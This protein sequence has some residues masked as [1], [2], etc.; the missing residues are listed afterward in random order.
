MKN[1]NLIDFFSGRP[2]SK[3]T[4]QDTD[5]ND[6]LVNKEGVYLGCLKKEDGKTMRNLIAE[7]SFK[8]EQINQLTAEWEYLS[9]ELLDFQKFCLA[10]LKYP[11]AA[12]VCFE[13]D[14]MMVDENSHVWIVYDNKKHNE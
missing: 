9:D 7:M 3:M 1:Q 4:Q 8:C 6:E 10:L 14:T 11:N 13:K 12:N 5:K 2:Y